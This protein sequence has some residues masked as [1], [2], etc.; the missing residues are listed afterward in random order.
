MEI[1]SPMVRTREIMNP[2]SSSTDIKWGQWN[3]RECQSQDH[4]R[5][6]STRLHDVFLLLPK[7]SHKPSQMLRHYLGK[8]HEKKEEI[9]KTKHFSQKIEPFT[10]DKIKTG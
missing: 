2:N 6:V 4:I 5:P 9:P 10:T 1:I 3:F 7:K 8:E